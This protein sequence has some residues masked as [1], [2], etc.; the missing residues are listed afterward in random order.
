M[1]NRKEGGRGKNGNKEMKKGEYREGGG[2]GVGK[3]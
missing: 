3:Y 2:G 1:E